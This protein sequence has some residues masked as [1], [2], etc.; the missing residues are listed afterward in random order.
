[1]KRFLIVVFIVSVLFV[2]S[3]PSSAD[4]FNL[5]PGLTSLET[6]TVGDPGNAADT[7]EH[8][9]SAAGQGSVSYTYNIGKYEITCAVSYTHLTLPTILLV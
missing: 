6:V 2:L 8:S 4:V 7:P 9:G 1:M 3:V 5:G